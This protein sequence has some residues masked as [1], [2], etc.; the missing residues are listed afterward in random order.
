MSG[1][2]KKDR[3]EGYITTI[4]QMKKI[5]ILVMNLIGNNFTIKFDEHYEKLKKIYN[6]NIDRI[7]DEDLHD[8]LESTFKQYKIVLTKEGNI[9][10]EICKD[11][12]GNL[13]LA[14]NT[15]VTDKDTVIKR[16]HY[17]SVAISKCYQLSYELSVIK[18]TF[19]I[20]ANVFENVIR[21][22]NKEVPLIKKWRENTKLPKNKAN[23]N[24][25]KSDL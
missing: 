10:L 9:L 15:F 13:Y 14:N 18:E 11:I 17:L 12:I 4:I 7:E 6:S 2:L 16:K 24:N 5:H 8:F 19:D 23:V 22:L 3:H 21:E 1:V 20:K 25:G